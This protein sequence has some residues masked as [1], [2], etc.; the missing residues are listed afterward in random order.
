MVYVSTPDIERWAEDAKKYEKIS[1]SAN[2][3]DPTVVLGVLLKKIVLA[4][5]LSKDAYDLHAI[6]DLYLEFFDIEIGDIDDAF[7]NF[8][9]ILSTIESAKQLPKSVLDKVFGWEIRTLLIRLNNQI[10]MLNSLVNKKLREEEQIVK[11]GEKLKE[12]LEEEQK[13]VK[14]ITY[15]T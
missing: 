5:V 12:I 6:D 13:S 1:K 8:M 14:E 10:L 4:S 7:K 3:K 11:Q 9:E 15:I 2:L